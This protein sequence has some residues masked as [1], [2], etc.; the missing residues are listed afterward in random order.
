MM[1]FFT[2]VIM[3]LL[4]LFPF[5]VHAQ[6]TISGK[7]INEEKGPIIGA[8][9][10]VKS[11][12]TQSNA[13]GNFT[14]V[15]NKGDILKVTSVGYSS[16]SIT[17]GSESNIIIQLQEESKKLEDVEIVT[18]LDIKRNARELGYSVQTVKG[19]DIQQT[20]RENFVTGLQGRVAGLTVTPTS[21]AAGASAGIVLRGFNTISGT[22]QP[23][24]V[25]DGIILDNQTLNSNSQSGSGIGLASDGNNRNNDNTN[26]IAD[27]NPND[28]ENVTVLKGPEATALYGSQASSGAI[29]ITTKKAK[30]TDGKVLISYD[31]SFRFQKETR[32]GVVN[33]DY[34]PGSSNNIL[35]TSPT[36]TG[37]FTSFGPRWKPGTTFYD[38]LHHFFQ[39]GFSQTHNLSAE[40]G[41][42]YVA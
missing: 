16:K 23:L 26:R 3:S 18:A 24:F 10:V 1:K 7:I 12:G 15:A 36:A 2:H 30:G 4:F 31:N 20:Q 38:N 25:V 19:S 9:V 37:S 13:S 40:F 11:K 41:T 8:T 6:I 35:F 17:V 34:G 32:F 29:V 28:I 22:N 42:K 14:I 5:A 33:N 21:G 27:L 39:I